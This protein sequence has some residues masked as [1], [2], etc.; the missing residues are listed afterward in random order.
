M[1]PGA[2]FI[3]NADSPYRGLPQ[4]DS[5]FKKVPWLCVTASRRFCRQVFNCYKGKY[6]S[7]LCR[8]SPFIYIIH[9]ARLLVKSFFKFF[10][11]NCVFLRRIVVFFTAYA[12]EKPI[13]CETQQTATIATISANA[14][15]KPKIATIFLFPVISAYRIVCKT[16]DT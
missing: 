6:T 3:S 10:F 16:I 15:S 9:A 13:N 7:G 5:S 8:S 12:F 2:L 4:D 14:P 11:A 1:Q